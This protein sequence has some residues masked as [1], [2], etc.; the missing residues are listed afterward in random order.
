MDFSPMSGEGDT[1]GD[2][3]GAAG[4]KIACGHCG[5]ERFTAGSAKLNTTMMTFLDLDWLNR[6]ATILICGNCGEIRWFIKEPEKM[7]EEQK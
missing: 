7:E 2:V 4:K 6:S 1:S 5:S 3:Y